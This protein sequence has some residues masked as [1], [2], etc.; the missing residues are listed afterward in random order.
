MYENKNRKR[1]KDDGG[2]GDIVKK[3]FGLLGW[4]KEKSHI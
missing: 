4:H 3:L 1:K 2:E